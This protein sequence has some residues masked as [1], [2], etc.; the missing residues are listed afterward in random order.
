MRLLRIP[1]DGLRFMI[2]P[3]LL[4]AALSTYLVWPDDVVWRF[5]K[6]APNTRLLEH[7]AFGAAAILLGV[8]LLLKVQ[9]SVSVRRQGSPHLSRTPNVANLLQAVGIGSLLPLPGFLLLVFGDLF[10]SLLLDR[11]LPVSEESQTELEARRISQAGSWK[12]ALGKHIGL[13]CAFASMLIFSMVLIDR[14]AD[15]LFGATALISVVA[16]SRDALRAG[17]RRA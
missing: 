4:V 7:V 8:A 10:T 14:M 3:A 12:D 9:A 2:R 17:A 16:S 5:I 13:C 6:A 11:W 1:V 15:A